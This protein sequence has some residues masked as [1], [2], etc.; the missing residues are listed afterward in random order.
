MNNLVAHIRILVVYRE[1]L[2]YFKIVRSLVRGRNNLV[3]SYDELWMVTVYI[4]QTRANI[5]RY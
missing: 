5:I 1:F 3:K 2:T 4:V